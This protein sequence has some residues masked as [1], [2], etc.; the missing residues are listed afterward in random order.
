MPSTMYRGRKTDFTVCSQ[1]LNVCKGGK[2]YGLERLE[3]G[4]LLLTGLMP[5]DE[6]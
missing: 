3:K 5:F 4:L 2:C 6:R 1:I